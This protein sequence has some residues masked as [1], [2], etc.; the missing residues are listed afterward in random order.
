METPM[1]WCRIL[2]A[3]S[4]PVAYRL[5]FSVLYHGRA[6]Y[7][8]LWGGVTALVLC[9]ISFRDGAVFGVRLQLGLMYTLTGDSDRQSGTDH[10]S[11]IS[12]LCGFWLLS[13]VDSWTSQMSTGVCY[14]AI[15]LFAN[16]WRMTSN[17][18]V[19]YIWYSTHHSLTGM[20][21]PPC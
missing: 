6:L 14:S 4:E 9:Y 21:A 15:L 7:A 2:L 18:Y 5:V 19:C 1:S 3:A 8:F 11:R 13:S 16:H 17:V 10:C 12:Y 20:H